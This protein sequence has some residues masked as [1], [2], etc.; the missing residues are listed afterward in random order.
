MNCGPCRRPARQAEAGLAPCAGSGG[1]SGHLV[2]AADRH[3]VGAPAAGGGLRLGHDL[4]AAFAGLA[5]GR[6]LASAAHD[7]AAP[8]GR[9]RS[10][11]L[12]AGERRQRMVPAKGEAGRPKRSAES[13]AARQTGLETQLGVDRKGT[14]LASGSWQPTST[15]AAPGGR[16]GMPSSPSADRADAHDSTNC[17]PTSRTLPCPTTQALRRRGIM[18]RIA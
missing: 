6:D 11:R 14:P 4:L 7:V 8:A 16:E 15:R 12:V 13:H 2:R 10:D 17:T 1:A 3:P 5:A 18:P 9:G